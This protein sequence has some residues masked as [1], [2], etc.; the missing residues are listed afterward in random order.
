MGPQLAGDLCRVANHIDG[1]FACFRQIRP[2]GVRPKNRGQ[3]YAAG[4]FD[5]LLNLF[6]HGRACPRTGI[7][8]EADGAGPDTQSVLNAS[9]NGR[10][11]VLALVKGLGVVQLQDQRYLAGEFYRACFQRP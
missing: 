9:G 11:G 10:A 6:V 4:L 8:G 2:P 5:Q 1:C 3:T 7:N